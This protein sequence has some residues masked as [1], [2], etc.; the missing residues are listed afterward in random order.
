M[1][2]KTMAVVGAGPGIGLAVARKWGGEGYAVALVAR[3]AGKLEGL[4]AQLASEGIEAAA[5]PAEVED[6]DRFAAALE[7]IKERFGGVDALYYGPPAE[8]ASLVPPR[9]FTV[10]NVQS[11]FD[12]T[13]IG[14]VVT[15]N[16][17]LAGM[18]EKGDGALLFACPMSAIEPVL[19]SANYAQ[20]TAALR[21]YAQA[22]YVDLASVGVYAGVVTIAGL[23]EEG[24]TERD[25]NLAA[26]ARRPGDRG[27]DEYREFHEDLGMR[28]PARV[29]AEALWDMATERGRDEEILGDRDI[30]M[31]MRESALAGGSAG[32][33]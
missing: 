7:S 30:V 32:R 31:K 2:T 1:T 9:Q 3:N 29:V 33:R 27:R 13:V 22:L 11:M 12:R 28:I 16:S 25:K 17:V 5:F 24:D 20:A 19:F 18:L 6:R 15:V 8:A 26:D 21:N 23:I 14:A 10:D 4:V